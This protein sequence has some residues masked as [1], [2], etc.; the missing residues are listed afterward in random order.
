MVV[1]L[2]TETTRRDRVYEDEL[3]H[4]LPPRI[5]DCHV[6]VGLDEHFGFISP[7]RRKEIW[8]I[9]VGITQT[10]EQARQTYRALFPSQHV[11]V[12]AFGNVY[13][14][15]DT[16]LEN[17]YVREGFMDPSNLAAGLFISRPEWDAEEVE[18]ALRSGFVGLK[19]YPDLAPQRSNEVS[20]YDFLPHAHLA[21]LEK[22]G[23]ILMLHLPRAGRL[24]DPN[25]LRE[26]LEISER[27]PS[28]KVIV[29]HIGRS[30]GLPS[31]MKGLP[32]FVDV[33]NVYFDTAANLNAEV[34]QCAL[35]TIGPDRVVFGSDLPVTT[36]RGEREHHG[37]GYVNYTDGLYSWN[38]NRK[39]PAEEANYTYFI[40]QEV[41]A[42][43]KAIDR[44]GLGWEAVQKVFYSNSTGLLQLAAAAA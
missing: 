8:A 9:E 17:D 15:A 18:Q 21:V 36:M 39:T 3:C 19:P 35:E 4:R 31:A 16:R 41:R 22:H 14:E 7:E 33:P 37:D 38:T 34:F 23:G 32:H 6:H 11:R 2:R 13:R 28:V 20:I 30:Y 43:L 1:N 42:L 5:V 12:L 44:S 27:Y 40:Y 25:N 10:W 24:A 29:A 26:L